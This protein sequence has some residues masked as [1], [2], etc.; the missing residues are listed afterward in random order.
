MPGMGFYS[1]LRHW[2]PVALAAAAWVGTPMR[3]MARVPSALERE[4][5]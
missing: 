2:L 5:G 4:P 3:R 1:S